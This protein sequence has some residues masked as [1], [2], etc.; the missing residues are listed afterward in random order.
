LGTLHCPQIG[1]LFICEAHNQSAPLP[2]SGLQRFGV[3]ALPVQPRSR[4]TSQTNT[5]A[6]TCVLLMNEFMIYVVNISGTIYF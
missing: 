1:T 5:I 4:P 3:G 6:I 2:S